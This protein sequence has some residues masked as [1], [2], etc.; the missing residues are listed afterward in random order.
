MKE[1]DGSPKGQL[2]IGRGAATMV[3]MKDEDFLPDHAIE[4][5]VALMIPAMHTGMKLLIE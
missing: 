5:A 3:D 4:D 1:R 2:Q